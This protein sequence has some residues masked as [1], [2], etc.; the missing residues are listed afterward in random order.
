MVYDRLEKD[1]TIYIFPAL[2]EGSKVVGGAMSHQPTV[3]STFQD[4]LDHLPK[5]PPY[6]G[7]VSSVLSR[8][9]HNHLLGIYLNSLVYCLWNASPFPAY[10]RR[11]LANISLPST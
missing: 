3:I 6:L 11:A 2:E 10:L 5:S 4:Y 7:R 8:G 9:H 1:S